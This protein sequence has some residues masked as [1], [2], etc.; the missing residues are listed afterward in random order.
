MFIVAPAGLGSRKANL[1]TDIQSYKQLKV[2]KKEIG[3]FTPAHCFI[4]FLLK[5]GKKF[6]THSSF[7]F[8]FA[9]ILSHFSRVQHFV[10]P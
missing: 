9:C 4:S 6:K 10:T 2:K 5:K 7:F 3:M 8:S 1:V